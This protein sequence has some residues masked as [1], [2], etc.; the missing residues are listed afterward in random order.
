MVV[1]LYIIIVYDVGVERV[2]KVRVYLKQ[3][4]NW[5]QNSV[6][7]GELTEAE[8]MKVMNGLR[9]V[10]D[11]SLD[12]VICYKT[13]DRKYLAIDEIGTKKAEITTII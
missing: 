13:K 4:L 9:D 5:V 11:E 6:L 8:Y 12:N 10:I 1:I 7:E 3:Y 2:N